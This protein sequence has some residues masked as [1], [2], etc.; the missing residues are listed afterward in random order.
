MGLAFFLDR[1]GEH[2][3]AGHDGGWPGF[4]SAL[5]V[6]PDAGLGVLAFTNTTSGLAPHSLTERAL[7]RLLG[8]PDDAD[9][10]RRAVPASPHLWPELAGIYKPL[11]GLGTNF[12]SWQLLGGEVEVGVQGGHLTARAPSPLKALRKG[13][14]LHAADPDDALAFEVR[15]GEVAIP[16]R[17]ARGENGQIASVSTGST[18]GGFLELHRRPRSTSLRLWGQIGAG[19]A[20]LGAGTALLRRLGRR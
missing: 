3:V 15:E 12:R 14:R 10:E 7:A 6:A 18:R 2:R 13:V 4:I 19:A 11:P 9:T 8:V 16:V 1:L 20:A 17:F 5:L